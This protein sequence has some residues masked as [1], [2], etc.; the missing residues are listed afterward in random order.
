MLAGAVHHPPPA[1]HAHRPPFTTRTRPE[2]AVRDVDLVL[3]TVGGPDSG[4]FLRTLRRGGTLYNVF[5]AAY[6]PAEVARLGVTTSGT[7]VRSGGRQLAELGRLLDAGT[8]R[9]AVDSTFPLADAREAH[10]RAERG[11]L[12]GKIVPTAA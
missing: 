6:D 8:L 5:L 9:V 10:E 12:R 11:H 1:L 3:D 2:E 7:Q 4:R